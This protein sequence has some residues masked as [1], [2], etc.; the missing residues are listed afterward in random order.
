M[1]SLSAIILLVTLLSV[2]SI[3]HCP[4]CPCEGEGEGELE[5]EPE[6]TVEGEIE[7]FWEGEGEGEPEGEEPAP[8]EQR[9]FAGIT[10]AW[11]PSGAF[12]MGSAMTPQE[13][14]E[15]YGGSGPDV[16]LNEHPLHHVIL[17][18]GFW[19]GIHEVTQQQWETALGENPATHV[20]GNL[21]VENI[22]WDDCQ[23]FIAELNGLGE[24]IFD[25]PA[26]AQWEYACRAGA[27]TEFH[28]GDDKALLDGYG[29]FFNENLVNSGFETHPVGEKLG[30]AWGLHDMH[31]NVWEFCRDWYNAEYY[32]QSP[33]LDPPGPETASFRVL[34]SGTCKRSE[35]KCRAA[36][37]SW[38]APL[39]RTPD[40]GLRLL[41]YA[42]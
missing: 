30:N 34:R 13:V 42:D 11:I 6:G 29:W 23:R 15:T 28:F 38:N 27:A 20:G 40:Q 19:L 2:V 9:V 24:G 26:E 14:Y 35:V 1:R 5:G 10:F 22:S 17:S 18:R 4:S 36:Y 21:P 7:G 32:A 16:F 33:E 31:G 12:E 25:L 3:P 39:F 37:R 41:R 8:G